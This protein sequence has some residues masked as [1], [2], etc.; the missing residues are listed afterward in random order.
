MT[1][2]FGA[3]AA[4]LDLAV[5]DKP[6]T[7]QSSRHYAGNRPPLLPSPLIRL[8]IGCVRP[9]GWTHRVLR[10]QADGFHGHLTEISSFLKKDNNAW[11]SPTGRGERGWEEVPYWLKGFQDCGYLLSDER[12][13]KEARIWIEG[14]I[15]SQ[16]PDGW[17]G[18]GEGRTGEATDLKGRDDLWPNMIMLFCLQSFHEQTNDPRVPELMR[19]YFKYLAGVPEDKFLVGYWPKMRAGDLLHSIYWHYNRT[20]EPWLLDLGHKVHRHAARWDQDVINW[21]NV[22]LAQGFREPATYYQQTRDPKHLRA[23]E[24]VWTKLRDLYGQVPGGLYG[25]DENC[26]PGFV[27]P[28]QA[29]ETCGMVEEMLSDEILLGITGEVKWADQCENVA[30]NSLPASMTSDLKALRYLTSPNLPQSD[31]VSKAPGVQNGGP[32]FHMD[33]HN[34]RCCQHNA[35]HGWP[36]FVQHLWYATPDQ[37]LAAVLYSPCRVTAKVGQGTQVTVA[38]NTRYPFDE[39]I[40]LSITA[41]QPERFPLYLRIPGWCDRP[42]LKLN[43]QP[44]QVA[45]KAGAFVRLARTWS[46]GDTLELTLP[47][48]VR[49]RVWAKN[50]NTVSVD[51]GP[52]TYSLKITERYVRHGGTDRWPAWDIFPGSPWNYG[53][54]LN[55][56]RPATSFQL[57]KYPWP[58]DDQPFKAEAVPVQLEA[59][60]RRIPPWQ[61]DD[62][63]LIREVQPSPA[64][65][66]EPLEEVTL[67]PMGAARLRIAAFPTI[68]S[69][70]DARAW[71]APPRLSVTASHC[72]EHDSV[73]AVTDGKVPQS[74]GD[75]SIPRFTWWDHRGTREWI[76][77]EFEK[78]TPVGKVEVYWFDDTGRGQCRRP[79]SWRLLYRKDAQW[80]PVSDPS[81]FGVDLDT[82][83]V[84]TFTPVTTDALRLEVQLRAGVSGGVLEWRV[85]P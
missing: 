51:R 8:P 4:D 81:A 57:V 56:M 9:A 29:V 44:V 63:G 71:T 40:S 18:P 65:S 23:T 79:E 70:P 6:D 38:E 50:H 58:A 26:R 43:G 78:P 46:N 21:H 54:V 17:F 32:M 42:V 37:G 27:G 13:M 48:D 74:S 67:I 7:T 77:R 85:S 84:T 62:K 68:G 76:Q 49:L 33:P 28:R 39:T 52:L 45:A 10:L 19:K 47:M 72:F 75:V 22:N 34:H 15:R 24:H 83:N 2:P 31:H 12:M 35:G 59:K 3:R 73:S 53:L 66:S 14:A 55:E 20:G 1:L 64:R 30:F 41:P 61:L 11:L 16:Q 80:Q 82:F 36:Y 60:A 25:S 5:V 69:G